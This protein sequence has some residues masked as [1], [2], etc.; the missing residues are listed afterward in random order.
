[1][2][3]F[4]AEAHVKR[5]TTPA[6]IALKVLLVLAVLVVL[7][8]S[9]F[10]GTIV[11]MIGVA[12]AF[13][14]VWFWP[15]FNIEWEYVFCDGQLDF[16]MI[17][18]GAKRKTQLRIDFDSME[19]IAKQDSHALDAYRQHKTKNFTSLRKDVVPYVVVASVGNEM[20]QIQFEPTSKMLDKM[21][22]KSPRKVIISPEDVYVEEAL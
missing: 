15:R 16:D 17:L 4:Y 10:F 12:L 21:K 6:T 7:F 2:N 14:V 5:K 1:M 20:L 8:F 18:G 13:L 9:N 19:I 3:D 11:L 22:M